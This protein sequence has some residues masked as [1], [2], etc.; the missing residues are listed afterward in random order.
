MSTNGLLRQQILQDLANVLDLDPEED[1]TEDSRLDSLDLSDDE[2][3]EVIREVGDSYK[4]SLP[5]NYTPPECLSKV[6]T[7]ILDYR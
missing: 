1:G 4:A 3:L 2:L 5:D 6:V 7:D